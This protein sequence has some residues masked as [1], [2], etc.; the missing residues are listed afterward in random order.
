MRVAR[1][2]ARRRRADARRPDRAAH[3]AS[4]A[5]RTSATIAAMIPAV[6]RRRRRGRLARGRR[7]RLRRGHQPPRLVAPR[8]ALPAAPTSRRPS[9]CC[10]R[11]RRARSWSATRRPTPP[12][13]RCSSR[14]ATRRVLMVP[15]VFGGRDVGLLELYRRHAM[16]W[17]SGEIERA[18]LLA[19]QLAAVIDLLARAVRHRPRLTARRAQTRRPR[20]RSWSTSCASTPASRCRSRAG[21]T[22][23]RTAA[24]TSCTSSP[25]GSGCGARWFQ[26]DH[27]DLPPHGR[28]AAVALG[29]EEVATRRAAAADDRARAASGRAGARS[30]PPG[31]TLAA[32]ERR[33]G[34]AALSAGGAARDRRAVRARGSRRSRRARPATCPCSTRTTRAPRSAATTRLGRRAAGVARA[35]CAPRWRRARAPSP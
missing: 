30:R 20:W 13:S 8:R 33:A 18:Q 10:A 23:R 5:R 24:S 25:R 21:A 12:R 29:A 6:L 11:A 31:V 2:A 14:P 9:T 27:Y 3:A 32:R 1:D 7:G 35:S 28:A 34:R 19:H 22:W 26:R 17:N 15:L 16:P 4:A